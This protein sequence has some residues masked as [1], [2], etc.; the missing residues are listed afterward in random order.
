MAYLPPQDQAQQNQQ[1]ELDVF[2]SDQQQG[3]KQEQQQ[4]TQIA[5]A[6]G[7]S[8][9]G[10]SAA[11]PPTAAGAKKEPKG[12]G[13]F[14]NIRKYIEANKPAAQNITGAVQK[15]IQSQT[16]SV[17]QQ[18]Q[19]QQ[20]EFKQRIAA[21]QS[22]IQDAS[23]FGQ[24]AIQQAG[25]GQL[26]DEDIQRFRNVATGQNTG[27]EDVT[28]QSFAQQDARAQALSGLVRQAQ[29]GQ[30]REELLRRT[31]GQNQQYTRGQRALDALILQGDQQAGQQL[32]RTA[33]EATS[34]LT[35][36]LKQ[37]RQQALTDTAQ[38]E[39]DEQALIEQL[40]SGV[41]TAKT[42]LRSNLEKRIE[43]N[44]ARVEAA[45]EA[46]KEG[47]K[48]RASQEDLEILGLSAGMAT[49][50]LNPL[51]YIRARE[52]STGDVASAEELARAEALGRLAGANQ[53]I[54]TDVS[55]V[56]KGTPIYEGLDRFKQAVENKRRGMEN[57][58]SDNQAFVGQ[59]WDKVGRGGSHA[60]AK[61]RAEAIYDHALRSGYFN[62]M[63]GGLFGFGTEDTHNI[64]K[65]VERDRESTMLRQ[66][67]ADPRKIQVG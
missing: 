23:Q 8:T 6:P 55:S 44:R 51:E 65:A 39:R 52:L 56:G 11:Q 29:T 58:L 59:M 22:R 61:R 46:L 53:D 9:I 1:S 19:K 36:T 49:Y 48:L 40:T 35:N 12:S 7:G 14:T 41:G 60:E 4:V 66:Q 54:I 45:R 63:R 37:A 67:L 42:D 20:D 38:L 18:I 33:Q 27:I 3:Q 15:N 47:G 25:S 62:H 24:Q 57:R 5:T 13:M 26:T 10:A 34:G 64:L 32:A 17:A 30:G 21:N 43:E 16:G 28:P 2:A 31:F 50:G